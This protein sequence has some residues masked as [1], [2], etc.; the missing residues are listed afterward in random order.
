MDLI[1]AA[2][3]GVA[4]ARAVGVTITGALDDALASML[5]KFDLREMVRTGKVVMARGPSAT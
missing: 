1:D 2:K 5:G 3:I 4:A